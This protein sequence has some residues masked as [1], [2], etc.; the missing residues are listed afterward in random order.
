MIN[1]LSSSRP[2]ILLVYPPNSGARPGVKGIYYPLG[3]GYIAAVLRKD[4]NLMIHDFN[5]DYCLG[6]YSALNVES[7]LR[8]HEYDFLL[9]GGVFPKHKCIRDIIEIS[10]K[11]SKAEIII[12]GSYLKSSI[13]VIA[14]YLKSDYYVIADG[15]EVIVKLL[16][17]L[18]NNRSAEA[19][20]GVAYHNGS[21]VCMN[22]P[23]T[24][25]TNV[26]DIPFPARDLLNFNNYKR[27]YALGYPLLYTA[28]VISSRG[29]PFNCLFCNPAF[30]RKV[31]VRS[32]GNILEEIILLQKKYN[33]KFIYFHDE[34][35]L[36]GAKGRVVDFCEYVLSKSKNR[37]F[38]GGTTNPK[39][40]DHEMLSL[41][42]RAGCIRISLGIESGSQTI[43]NEMRKKND[44]GQIKDIV[45]YCNKIGIEIDFSLL[46]NTF[47]E[48]KDTLLE[49]KNYLKY[50]NKFFFRE[51]FSINYINPVHGTDI[52]NE[53]RERGLINNDELKHILD[54]GKSSR[55][56]LRH[57][58]TNIKTDYFVNLVDGINRELANDYF[59]KH[60][61]QGMILKTTNLTHFRLK[62]TLLS[63]SSENIRPVVEG[64]LWSLCRGNDNSIIG[65]IYKK[66][67]YNNSSFKR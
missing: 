23:A 65:K 38:W 50:F 18:V 53:A 32:P 62:E 37:F 61:V 27:Y 66:L 11:I 5:Y 20:A 63:L 8:S 47:S 59:N 60:P 10:R 16:E 22:M 2:K 46:T 44:L 64:L 55:Y 25:V 24:P 6:H 13:K 7:I 30:G 28:Y 54:L 26:D 51:P 36:G 19:I 58:L 48:T 45:A 57:N 17:C 52:Y 31:R 39:M 14:N 15:E 33:C 43:L 1:N 12:G 40:L 49:T 41:M 35:L 4:Y 56:V 9:I 21:D 67:V 3:I 42:K 29:C 34:V